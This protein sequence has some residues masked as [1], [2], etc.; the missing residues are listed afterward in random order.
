MYSYLDGPPLVIPPPRPLI[1]T[2]RVDDGGVRI[3]GG[4][5]TNQDANE[6]KPELPLLYRIDFDNEIALRSFSFHKFLTPGAVFAMAGLIPKSGNNQLECGLASM[7]DIRIHALAV[8]TQHRLFLGCCLMAWDGVDW[9]AGWPNNTCETKPMHKHIILTL[10]G[11][12][13]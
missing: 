12:F 9:V 8:T 6:I 2:R 5:L 4:P 1:P 13:E 11:R 7:T 10:C 3:A